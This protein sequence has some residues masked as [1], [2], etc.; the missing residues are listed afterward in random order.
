M[1]LKYMERRCSCL[2]SI[3]PFVPNSTWFYPITS[4]SRA[5]S[6]TVNLSPVMTDQL[7]LHVYPDT[8]VPSDPFE[9]D[10]VLS[11]SKDSYT[12]QP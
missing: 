5:G 3:L 10:L 7:C 9:V 2:S 1:S 12:E 4:W 11:D 6:P 8:S